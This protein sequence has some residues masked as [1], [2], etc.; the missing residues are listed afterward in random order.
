MIAPKFI[1]RQTNLVILSPFY[2][3]NFLFMPSILC[4]PALPL[5]L[6][7]SAI[8]STIPRGHRAPAK[9]AARYPMARTKTMLVLSL[10]ATVLTAGVM[11][12]SAAAQKSSM[13]KPQDKLAL[14]EE[15][16]RQLLPLMNADAY[17][18]VSKQDYMCFMEAEFQR[19]DK[20]KN[21]ALDVRAL[22]RPSITANRYVGK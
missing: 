21:G 15:Q 19:L 16:V 8:R 6:Y 1:Q 13:A 4:R 3:Q 12:R 14:G 7:I 22:S 2:V 10:G 17:G 9:K 11:L 20:S 18:R 5:L